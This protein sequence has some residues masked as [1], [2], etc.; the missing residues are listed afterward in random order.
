MQKQ[1]SK[2]NLPFVWIYNFVLGK[3]YFSMILIGDL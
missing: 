1:L 2:I 3:I